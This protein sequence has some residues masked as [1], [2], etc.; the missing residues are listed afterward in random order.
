MTNAANV[1]QHIYFPENWN[2][3]WP[4]FYLAMISY[5]RMGKNKHDDAPDAV[6]GIV[7]TYLEQTIRVDDRLADSARR[8]RMAGM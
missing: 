3:R 1:K 6:T 4:D 2:K 5:Q 8:A 7:E